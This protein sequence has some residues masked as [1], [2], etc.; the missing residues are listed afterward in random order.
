[1]FGIPGRCVAFKRPTARLKRVQTPLVCR[2]SEPVQVRSRFEAFLSVPVRVSV[3]AVAALSLL[4]WIISTVYI[5]PVTSVPLATVLSDLRL[6]SL[7]HSALFTFR[8]DVMQKSLG[9]KKVIL[10]TSG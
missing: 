8:C 7:L 6:L 9:E 5:M 1:M 2:M 4:P 10:K 3:R